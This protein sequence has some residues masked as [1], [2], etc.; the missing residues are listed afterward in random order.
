MH[1]SDLLHSQTVTCS[2]SHDQTVTPRNSLRT[3]DTSESRLSPAPL[4]L[5]GP[6]QQLSCNHREVRPVN[7]SLGPLCPWGTT[8]EQEKHRPKD[9]SCSFKTGFTLHNVE[10]KQCHFQADHCTENYSSYVQYSLYVLHFV[11]RGRNHSKLK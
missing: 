7:Q 10:H 8:D 2:F 3:Q 1:A 5:R 11:E 9:T 6:G 4:E